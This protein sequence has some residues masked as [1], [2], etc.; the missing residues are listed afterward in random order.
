[1]MKKKNKLTPAIFFL[2]IMFPTVLSSIAV[3]HSSVIL[4]IITAIALFVM[5]KIPVFKHRENLWMFVLATFGTLPVNF[6]LI[7]KASDL[8]SIFGDTIISA[9]FAKFITYAILFALEQ[10]ILGIITRLFYR[11]Q[12]KLF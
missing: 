8:L 2:L 3:R 9:I 10:L 12:Y 1:M 4:I 6:S 7:K 5:L 11:K